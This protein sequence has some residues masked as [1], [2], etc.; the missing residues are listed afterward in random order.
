MKVIP[1]DSHV[2][3]YHNLNVF[4]WNHSFVVFDIINFDIRLRNLHLFWTLI[5]NVNCIFFLRFIIWLAFL[6]SSLCVCNFYLFVFRFTIRNE[7]VDFCFSHY[8]FNIRYLKFTETWRLIQITSC[9]P[10]IVHILLR[11]VHFDILSNSNR[12]FVCKHCIFDSHKF[13]L[14]DVVSVLSLDYDVNF[15]PAWLNWI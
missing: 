11:H 8:P 15:G 3:F 5:F 12:V 6:W 13:F 7:F 2:T 14:A 4:I 10:I 9:L 1:S